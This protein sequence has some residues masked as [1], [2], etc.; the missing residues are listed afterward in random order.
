YGKCAANRASET[1]APLAL[2]RGRSFKR[3]NMNRRLVISVTS[4]WLFLLPC[5]LLAVTCPLVQPDFQRE[6]QAG[7]SA[8]DQSDYLNATKHFVKANELQ[9]NKCSECYV[10]LARIAL[11][12]GGLQ[13]ALAETEKAL[14]TA[15][16]ASEKANAHLY[17]GIIL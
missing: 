9:Q 1:S 3:W 15:T 11:G 2:A 16:T 7:K 12:A 4:A 6:F 17:Q 8:V 5:N 13:Q 14:V 10:W